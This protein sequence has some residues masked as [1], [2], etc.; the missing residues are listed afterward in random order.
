LA[1][2]LKIIERGKLPWFDVVTRGK[3]KAWV[4]P[5]MA[6]SVHGHKARLKKARVEVTQC[7][8]ERGSGWD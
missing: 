2:S 8:N 5:S 4:S 7:G 3:D 6:R 1:D